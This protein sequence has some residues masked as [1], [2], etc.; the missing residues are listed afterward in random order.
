MD[1]VTAHRVRP[2]N[3]VQLEVQPASIA[4]HLTPDVPPPDGG[5]RG[6]T[7]RT[8]HVLLLRVL[9]LR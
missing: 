7:V 2:V 9:L 5:G 3:A 1:R 6:T 8:G 4:N